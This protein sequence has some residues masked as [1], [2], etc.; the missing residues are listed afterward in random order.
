MNREIDNIFFYQSLIREEL[1][2]KN[3]LN[4][5]IIVLSIILFILI[6]IIVYQL[7]I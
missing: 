7:F 4:T 6:S 3:N 5:R 1:N 2:K